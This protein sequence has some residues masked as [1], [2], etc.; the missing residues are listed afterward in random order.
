MDS[1]EEKTAKQAVPAV[2]LTGINI[3]KFSEH[4]LIAGYDF[5]DKD[6]VLVDVGAHEGAVTR[7]FANLG[8][9]VI[10][11]EPE[12]EN[13]KV[14]KKNTHGMNNVIC[15]PKAVSDHTG[16]MVPFYT[17]REHYGIHALRPFHSTHREADYKVVTVT[18][19]D[20][21]NDLDIHNTTFLKID[22]EGA[23]YPALQS[24]DLEKFRPE[25][26]MT[27]F[28]DSRS[29]ITFGYTHHDMA[30]YMNNHGYVAFVSE[31]APIR[32]Y[33]RKG[34]RG[35]SHVWL[36]CERYPLDHDPAWGNMIFIKKPDIDRFSRTLENY[37]S[38][39]GKAGKSRIG[40][41]LGY[42]NI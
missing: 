19:D 15:I 26:V 18:L 14:L 24:I 27:E 21:L 6:R 7:L 29:K 40:R 41:L 20:A 9:T 17:S 5:S 10:A 38:R 2:L 31:W 1:N 3:M 12:L 34:V 23:D 32:E 37:I 11:F 42:L 36:S 16:D 25:I 39:G 28:M 33:G 35:E 13:R 30:S 22:V 4:E 8:W